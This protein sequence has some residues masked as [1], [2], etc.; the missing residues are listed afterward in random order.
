MIR[1]LQKKFVI[2][3]MIAITALL[4]VLLGAIN[5]VNIGIVGNDTEKT[6]RMIAENQGDIHNLN[7]QP[8]IPNGDTAEG[9]LPQPPDRP[10]NGGGP[11]NDYD[12]FM[13]STFFTVS[14]D[15]DGAVLYTDVSRTSTVSEAAAQEMA[16]EVRNGAAEGKTGKYRYRIAESRDGGSVVVFLDTSNEILSYLRVLFLSAAIGFVSWGLMLI[17]VILLSKRAIRPIAESMEKQKQFVTN[18]G[19]EI[20]TPLAII[21][22]NTEAME[23]Y[24]GENKWSRNIKEQTQRLSGLMQELLTLA[25]MDEGGVQIHAEE[26]SLSEL[27]REQAAEFEQP[28]ENKRITCR[29]R[30]ASGVI[31]YADKKHIEQLISILLDNAVK[32]TEESGSMELLLEKRDKRILMQVKNTCEKLPEVPAEKLFD[33]FYRADAARTQKNGGYG[34]GLSMARMLVSSN[35]GTITAEYQGTNEIAFTVR[36]SEKTENLKKKRR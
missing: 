25:R 35:H 3:A 32:Y 22:S 1:T 33:R 23:L 2:T 20:K 27:L 29:T 7:M 5:V 11:K 9:E 28:M 13:S 34:I 30:I 24:T 4:L 8:G 19:H 17:L 6:L 36:F 16:Q 14:Y 12:T 10:D 21:Q 31:L 15:S 18:A 26:F